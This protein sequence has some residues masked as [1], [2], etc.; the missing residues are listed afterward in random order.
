MSSDTLSK[1]GFAGSV[2]ALLAA[3]CCVLPLVIMLV[4]LGGS[5]V[6]VFGAVAAV[7][8]WV[9]LA[10]GL[11]IAFAWIVAIRRNASRQTYTLLTAGTV[12]TVFAWCLI[13]YEAVVNDYLI[14]LM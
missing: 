10:A 1:T 13:S 8:P 7:S 2:F 14:T 12:L 11:I 5:W 4:G 3:A 6:A 9:A